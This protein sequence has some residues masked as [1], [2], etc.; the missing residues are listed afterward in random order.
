MGNIKG[1]DQ[2]INS[3]KYLLYLY[4][5]FREH[6]IYPPFSK[7]SIKNKEFQKDFN[8]TNNSQINSQF[9]GKGTLHPKLLLLVDNKSQI[10]KRAYRYALIVENYIKILEKYENSSIKSKEKLFEYIYEKHPNI[11]KHLPYV[12][13]KYNVGY[14]FE[15]DT[16]YYNITNKNTPI[17]VSKLYSVYDLY[18]PDISCNSLIYLEESCLASGTLPPLYRNK[19]EYIDHLIKDMK[20]YM[21]LG[22]DQDDR[23]I[24]KLKT[25]N[26]ERTDDIRYIS[27]F[28]DKVN[29]SDIENMCNVSFKVDKGTNLTEKELIYYEKCYRNILS[30][31]GLVKLLLKEKKTMD[32]IHPYTR[33]NIKTKI[34]KEKNKSNIYHISTSFRQWNPDCSISKEAR[35]KVLK[36]RDLTDNFDLHS[37]IFAVTKLMNTGQFDP[38][39]D[40]KEE[41]LKTSNFTKKDGTPISKDDLKSLSMR[42][43]FEQSK[44]SM[45]NHYERAIRLEESDLPMVDKDTFIK[46][47]IRTEELVGE[48]KPFRR[49]IFAIESL[50][51]MKVINWF[52]ENKLEVMNVFDCFYFNRKE[53]ENKFGV[54]NGVDY[55]KKVISDKAIETYKAIKKV[56]KRQRIIVK[57]L[58]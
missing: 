54:V 4:C 19:V 40:V 58:W 45:W 37:A 44:E 8:M 20:L 14:S 24:T 42:M 26:L 31:V 46:M 7:I 25:D 17:N 9:Q 21:L 52:F 23:D 12:L 18:N 43:Y 33:L 10:N 41:F 56:D 39:W 47:A 22:L 53:I 29:S 32:S 16:K 11:K 57:P 3:F 5:L 49:T 6:G 36:E 35:K 48:I 51:E 15:Y 2:D 1:K 13:S 27:D 38:D 55:V 34:Y 28:F 30:D 50:L